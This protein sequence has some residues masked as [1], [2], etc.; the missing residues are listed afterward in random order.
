MRTYNMRQTRLTELLPSILEWDEQRTLPLVR[1]QEKLCDNDQTVADFGARFALQQETGE[2]CPLTIKEVNTYLDQ[3][4]STCKYSDVDGMGAR[5]N[6]TELGSVVALDVDGMGARAN[7][8]E[9]GSVVA[10]TG[11]RGATAV[12]RKCLKALFEVYSRCSSFIYM[13]SC[14]IENAAN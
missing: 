8:T 2:P 5:A 10:L 14:L 9:L 12:P 7:M 4:A 1:W 11:R 6:M 3:I 13:D